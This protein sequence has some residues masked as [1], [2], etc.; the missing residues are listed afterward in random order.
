MTQQYCPRE[1]DKRPLEKECNV[2]LAWKLDF[3]NP[4][5]WLPRHGPPYTVAEL[6][7]QKIVRLLAYLPIYTAFVVTMV[8]LIQIFGVPFVGNP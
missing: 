5:R 2:P 4:F 7:V 3:N 8:L 1:G 6:L